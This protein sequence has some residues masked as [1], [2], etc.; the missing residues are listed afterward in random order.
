[1]TEMGVIQF[2]EKRM[3]AAR[4]RKEALFVKRREVA[5]K[6]CDGS[7]TDYYAEFQRLTRM[8]DDACSE[9]RIYDEVISLLKGGRK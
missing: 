5:S 1:M 3:D 4:E 2:L 7:N 9:I 6:G 8:I